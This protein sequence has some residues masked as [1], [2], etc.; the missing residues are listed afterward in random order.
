MVYR[1]YVEKKPGFDGEAQSLRNEL[2]SLLGIKELSGLR[3]LNRY[4]VEGIDEAL[5]EQ[6][7]PTV[8]SEP[9]VDNTY[10]ELP[11]ADG[12]V[13]FAVEYLPGQFDQRADSAAECIQ[14]ISQGERPLVRS[15][16][17]YLLEGT[18]TDEQLAEIK[19]YVINP[20]EAREASLDTKATLKMEYPV[21]TEV[22]VLDGFNELDEE[23]LKKFIDEKGLAMDLGDIKFCQEYFRSEKR[24][25]TITEIK[26]IDTYWSD[27]CR[28][29]TFGTILDDV[30]IDD[31]V[32]QKAFDRYM[33]MRADLGRENKPRCMMD[34][35]TIGAKE[36]KKQG[37]LKNLDESE[38]INACTV[39]IKCDVNGKDED[40]LFLFKNETHN[41]P[42]EIEPFGGAATCIGGAIRD[43]L[44]GRS[45]VYQAMRVTGAGD[46]LKPVG[47]T[48]PG[49]L[50]QRKLVTTAA[51]GYSSYGN[52]IGLA[53][54]QVDEIYHPG[55][56]AKRMEIGAVVGATPASHVRRECPAP[57]DVIVLLGGRVAE[58][59][60]L[61]DISTGASNDI[62]RATKIVRAMVTKYGMSDRLGPITYGAD[63]S[64]PFLGKEMGHVSN[65][66][67]ETA[68]E[69]DEEI[70]SIICDA[71]DKTKKVLSEHIDLLH[72][73]AGVL[74][75]REK[76]DA[77]EF[78]DVMNGKLLPSAQ[79]AAAGI[80]PAEAAAPETTELPTEAQ[81]E[82][83]ANTNE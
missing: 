3:L 79:T 46:P 81:T 52:Q 55:Y 74:F 65:Y 69:I 70:K 26:M 37:I 38:E 21:P 67:E 57:G 75:E 39:K 61:D 2:V 42:T 72:R 35:A 1:I 78:L 41:H 34:L 40:W 4:D 77:D 68:A 47:E 44:S 76:L 64:N 5:F 29:T 33:A 12:C 30:Q 49:K 31:A 17:V 32:V 60:V 15:A 24:D 56:V 71:Y 45:Y 22:A 36:L 53:T 14:L 11:T 25:P 48:L 20:V 9:P 51:A 27:H 58:A 66:S 54:G 83:E 19:K 10:A 7:V 73:L 16:R 28:H 13:S 82:P 80:I 6:C 63:S 50:P 59:L 18:L 62:E 43:P 23:G 8:F